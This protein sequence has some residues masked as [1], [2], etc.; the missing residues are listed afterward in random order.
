MLV[1]WLY[2]K[3][4]S[5]ILNFG[6]FVLLEYLFS[7]YIS[8]HL[9]CL[10]L[11][12]VKIFQAPLTLW[13]SQE[14]V[15]IIWW[16][17]QSRPCINISF[18]ISSLKK[19]YTKKVPLLGNCHYFSRSVRNQ[20][21]KFKLWTFRIQGWI[22]GTVSY[23]RPLP[24]IQKSLLQC[25]LDSETDLGFSWAFCHLQKFKLPKWREKGRRW[26]VGYFSKC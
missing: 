3:W 22:E 21:E 12:L 5:E 7:L 2:W 15:L 14:I 10:L 26:K 1:N 18:S 4:N 25:C 13:S 8:C 6:E 17:S 11:H 9:L 16:K 19:N 20:M 24:L 23:Q